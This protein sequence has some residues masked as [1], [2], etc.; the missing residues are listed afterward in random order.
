MAIKPGK[1]AFNKR[2]IRLK[3]KFY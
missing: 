2:D 3:Y 1:K